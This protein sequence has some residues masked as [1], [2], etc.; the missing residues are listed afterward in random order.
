MQKYDV[1]DLFL[2]LNFEAIMVV[3][4]AFLPLTL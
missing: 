1:L 3:I 2:L 4:I